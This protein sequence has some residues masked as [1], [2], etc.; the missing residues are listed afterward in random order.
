MS[1]F[2]Q[3]CDINLT[4]KFYDLSNLVDMSFYWRELISWNFI[5]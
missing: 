5:R 4:E 2:G 3:R 1:N